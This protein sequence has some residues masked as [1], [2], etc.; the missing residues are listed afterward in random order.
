MIKNELLD[1]FVAQHDLDYRLAL[2]LEGS[3]LVVH[4]GRDEDL[5]V[6]K[7]TLARREVGDLLWL[8]S[9]PEVDG[10]GSLELTRRGW[11][12]SPMLMVVH[13]SLVNSGPETLCQQSHVWD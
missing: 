2:V 1:L 9:M 3:V 7:E 8:A 12:S 5:G 11:P 4:V 10:T 6:P 13:S